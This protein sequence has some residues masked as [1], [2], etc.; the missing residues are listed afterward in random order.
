MIRFMRSVQVEP[1][2]ER[3]ATQ[4]AIEIAQRVS[5]IAGTDVRV[6]IEV[7]GQA[8]TLYWVSDHPDLTAVARVEE[9]LAQDQQTHAIAARGAEFI[10]GGTVQDRLLQAV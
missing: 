5:R 6:F 4:W 2:Q 10:V 1:G 7:F 9:Q 8:G 3:A